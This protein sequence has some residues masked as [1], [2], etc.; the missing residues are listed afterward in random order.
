MISLRDKY[1]EEV[2]NQLNV[3]YKELLSN[4]EN[5]HCMKLGGIPI[6]YHD[7][8][9]QSMRSNYSSLESYIIHD[10]KDGD[11]YISATKLIEKRNASKAPLLAI[12]PP[13]SHTAAE[14]SYSNSTFQ[15]IALAGI[16]KSIA[17][18]LLESID[19]D[20]QD[21]IKIVFE[22]LYI[23]IR[24]PS[25]ETIEYI[26]SIRDSSDTIS[27]GNSLHL[28]G[29][30]PDSKLFADKLKINSRLNYN[31]R[32]LNLMS[33]F[34]KATYVRIRELPIE[35]NSI[36]EQLVNFFKANP[37]AN[38]KATITNLIKEKYS[39]L[40]F[41]NWKIPDI[42]PSN[43]SVFIDFIKDGNGKVLSSNNT[44]DD[45]GMLQISPNGSAKIRLKFTMQPIP[46][47]L[48][49]LSGYKVTLCSAEDGSSILELSRFK[50]SSVRSAS[51]SKTI[52]V[53]ANNVDDGDVFLRVEA[54]DEHGNILNTKDPFKDPS[55]Q[56]HYDS[57]SKEEKETFLSTNFFKKTSESENFLIRIEETEEAVETKKSKLHN[58]LEGY[59]KFRIEGIKKEV[60][61]QPEK[62]DEEC[63]WVE[64]KTKKL[65]STYI[66]KYNNRHHYQLILSE[67]LN[68]IERIFLSNPEKIGFAEVR[69]SP[70]STKEGFE[71][72]NLVETSAKEFVTEEF[73]RLRKELF[74]TIQNDN[75]LEKGVFESFEFH[76]HTELIVDYLN[77]FNKLI[78]SINEQL[79]NISDDS[80]DSSFVDFSKAIMSID[81]VFLKTKLP[82]GSSIESALLSPLHPLKLYWSL[83]QL[84]AFRDFE[85]KTKLNPSHIE[86]WKGTLD[87][88]FLEDLVPNINPVYLVNP[89]NEKEFIRAGELSYGWTLYSNLKYIDLESELNNSQL[90]NYFRYLLNV[91]KSQYTDSNYLTK[92][93]ARSLKNYVKQHPYVEKIVINIINAGEGLP[94]AEAL[95]QLEK[96]NSLNDLNYEIRLI[97]GL[98]RLVDTGKGLR[99]L[100]NPSSNLSEE[101]ESFSQIS[102]NVLFPK[103]R[104]SINSRKDL[105]ENQSKFVAHVSF[106]LQP[107]PLT[108]SLVQPTNFAK[109]IF[110]NGLRIETESQLSE[111]SNEY[112]W[113][114][115]IHS[116]F[117]DYNN[118]IEENAISLFH[119]LQSIAA[120]SL[121]NGDTRS[122]PASKLLLAK[123][124]MVFLSILH[125]LSD[126][127]VTIDNNI[128]PEIFDL[129][130]DK[131]EIPFLLDYIPGQSST[132]VTSFLTTHPT[133]EI[134]GLI[135]PHLK[136]LNSQSDYKFHQSD[137]IKILDDIRA[138]SSSLLMQLNLS[139]NQSIEVIAIALAKRVLQKKKLLESNII[140]PIDLH[141]DLFISKDEEKSASRADLLLCNIDVEKRTFELTVLEVKCR[142]S[143]N[144]SEKDDLTSKMAD[145]INNTEEVLRSHFDMEYQLSDDRL[146]R[147]F[148]SLQ[149]RNI[150][151]FYLNRSFRYKLIDD[152][153]FDLYKNFLNTLEDGYDITFR[154][155]GFIFSYSETKKHL[156]EVLHDDITYFTFGKSL[157]PEILS[158]EDNLDTYRLEKEDEDQLLEYFTP[159]ELSDSLKNL[160]AQ[161]IKKRE[162][163]TD[164]NEEDLTIDDTKNIEDQKSDSAIPAEVI[165][166]VGNE[167][168]HSNKIAIAAVES[169]IEEVQTSREQKNDESHTQEVEMNDVEEVNEI[170]VQEESINEITYST[171]IGSNKES[172]QY[173]ILGTTSNGKK[174]AI[175][176]NETSTISLFGVQ[177]GGK[178]YSIGSVVEMVLKQ[179]DNV[180]V[181]K[182][183]MAGV[184]FHYSESMDYEPE[185]TSMNVP[186]DQEQ[187]LKMLKEI[188]GA[189]PDNIDD[190]VLLVPQDKLEERKSEFPSLDVH[191]IAFNSNELDVK[192]WMFLLG[193]INNDSTYI[194]QLKSIMKRNR[195]D[196]SL[197]RIRESVNESEQ[198]SNSQRS[199]ANQRLDFAQDYINDEADLSTLLM[200]GRLVVVDLRDE[201]I[202]KDEALGLFV[203]MLNIFSSDK[204]MSKFIVFDE[205]H[206]YMDNK[207]LA[208]KIVEA[209]REMRHKGVSIMIASQDPPSLPN[210][211]IELS[212]IVITHKF[213]SPT[214][215]KHIQKSIT[216]LNILKPSDMSS[217]GTGEAFLWA[218]KASDKAITIKPKKI[219]IRPRFTKHG[220]ATIKATDH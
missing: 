127:V 144:A 174:I 2:I 92:I 28:L 74:S 132:G 153:R 8:L 117:P 197:T 48:P 38:N 7:D 41:S 186:N 187:E 220:G 101:A 125:E 113:H 211:I 89:E 23:D 87:K 218:S 51:R 130:S 84:N 65:T 140:I 203:I 179:V 138:V 192:S 43:V 13:N 99:Q 34:S 77:E 49:S 175:D 95:I 55:V 137:T 54:L 69:L 131:M 122:L 94:F 53:H 214:W 83:M 39:D 183:P 108:V 147:K 56:E 80:K 81:V 73:L 146:D 37:E 189:E 190:I 216:N 19:S 109:S 123:E 42:D 20:I 31:G 168:V 208:G 32:C 121:S 182:S 124:D 27:I 141:K 188:Y 26:L 154:K 145:Q 152:T 126:W 219:K 143:L 59:Y 120:F 17:I 167:V 60:E 161:I 35:K 46:S 15:N 178:S 98:N 12:I 184:I 148:K 102:K 136:L 159:Q 160:R 14:D 66:L 45:E 164:I 62:V 88:L 47:E 96:E 169:T 64:G 111:K 165:P 97:E 128:G 185:F 151:L 139:R 105:L 85:N 71:N 78:S 119:S 57:L 116:D 196:L 52:E 212:S 25:I 210:E 75:E 181:L 209:I 135:E 172:A 29:L 63:I 110:A 200:P 112:T 114:N 155:L 11:Y 195:N 72:E 205:A 202:D 107:F 90:I 22:F 67:K 176:L 68:R 166:E 171:L 18:R 115:Y 177:G 156:K 150:L 158:D 149:L 194:K 118:S 86:E 50:N 9:I 33:D 44:S 193:A 79:R 134:Q 215:L 5:G 204:S 163:L 129:K 36:Q 180:N 61:D 16:N 1:Y 173:G 170:E 3:D 198:L 162:A 100:L 82:N 106:L 157:I 58:V 142:S 207:A 206:K 201:F 104:Y 4:A 6:A 30:I 10:S 213:N 76:N 217:L 91:D 103:L 21:L 133:S 40:N 70:I 199:L 93:I 191:P 24:K